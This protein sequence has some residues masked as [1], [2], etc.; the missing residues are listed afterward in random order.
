MYPSLET[1]A[2]ETPTH[3]HG[4]RKDFFQGGQ[5]WIFPKFFPGEPK[6]V[7][8]VFYPSKLKKQPFLPISFQSRGARPSL[9]TPMRT[10]RCNCTL[11]VLCRIFCAKHATST[12]LHS[13]STLVKRNTISCT[14]L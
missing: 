7:K 11:A 13:D 10:T 12:A 6:V 8:F 2:L 1:P 3:H 5:E 9:P 4:R 14:Q